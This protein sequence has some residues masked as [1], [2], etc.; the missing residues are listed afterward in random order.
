MNRPTHRIAA[1]LSGLLLSLCLAAPSAL[2]DDID[3]YR[4]FTP[5]PAKPPL[6]MVMLDLSL[7]L[8]GGLDPTDVIC[9]DAFT[10]A[11]CELLRENV[12]IESFLE[13]I[14]TSF[15]A[16]RATVLTLTFGLVDLNTY[17]GDIAQDVIDAVGVA[18]LAAAAVLNG[19][20]V[21][22]DTAQTVIY[23]LT[24]TIRALT[25]FRVGVMVSHSDIG[26]TTVSGGQTYA[27][28]FADLEAVPGERADTDACSNG[29]YVFV[30]FVDLLNDPL[31]TA[32]TQLIA[33]VGALITG[34]LAAEDAALVPGDPAHPYQG[35]ELYLEFYRYLVGGEVFNGH[36]G[37]F[38]YGDANAADNLDVSNPPLAWDATVETGSSYNS[39]ID[40]FGD[41]DIINVVNVMTSDSSRDAD[42]DA[43][44]L[45]A[46]PG[47]DLDGD[48]S[49]TFAELVVFAEDS[50][51]THDG[52]PF[53][54]RSRFIVNGA[55]QDAGALRAL[56]HSVQDSTELVEL[57]VDGASAAELLKTALPIDTSLLSAA[58]TLD[59]TQSG[60]VLGPALFTLFRPT[61]DTPR[62]PG[63]LKKLQLQ[64]D[65][66]DSEFQFVDAN[67]QQAISDA[68]R[69]RSNALT[70]WTD[71]GALSGVA[72][73]GPDTT[74]GGAG[75]RI[76]GFTT[77]DPGAD[78]A[79]GGRVIYYDRSTPLELA[80]L[81]ANKVSVQSALRT[82]L[83]AA[84]NAE[85]EELLYYVRG[86]DVGTTATPI[87]V[88]T[89]KRDWFMGAVFH[90]RPLAINY[91]QRS[92]YSGNDVRI[93]FGAADG[94]LRMIANTSAGGAESGAE[95]WAFMPRE[96]MAQQKTL[97]DEDNAAD[98]P[99]GVD[100]PVVAFVKDR[101]PGGSASDGVIDSA[102]P[103][104]QVLAFFGLRRGGSAYYGLDITD[105]DSPELLW[106]IDDS[107]TDFASLGRTFSEPVVARLSVDEGGTVSTR[108]VL[109]FGG[110]YD[111]KKDSENGSGGNV[112]TDDSVGN[113]IYIV[114]AE[115]GD[116][117]W[118]AEQGSFT[119]ADFYADASKTY[120][121][122]LLLDSIPSQLTVLDTDG[123]GLADRYYVGDTGGRL[124]RGDL[125]GSD[126]NSWTLTPLASIGRHNGTATVATDR[127]FFHRP[128][129]APTRSSEGNKFDTVL[130]GSGDRAD[131]ENLSA[132]DFLY[133][134]RDHDTAIGKTAAEV[135]TTEAGLPDHADFQDI[136]NQCLVAGGSCPDDTALATG[137]RLE[138]TQTGEKALSTPLTTGGVVLFSSFVP[139]GATVC[140]PAE[141]SARQY[142][143][144]LFN[145]AP[146]NIERY[147]SDGDGNPRTR[148]AAAT[149]FPAVTL[150]ISASTVINGA[151][152]DTL[153]TRTRWE[154][155]WRE[156]LGEE[157]EPVVQP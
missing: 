121:H 32:E 48:G 112:G 50:G 14:G 58:V 145:G 37:Y 123:D 105:P 101:G 88:G 114:D 73:D 15:A 3:V 45:Q 93:L 98:F 2:A 34:G 117:I 137:W 130:I 108:T 43:Q 4:N 141:G 38:D 64:F 22:V 147:T 97:R 135:I 63:N 139:P 67:G 25:D 109:F 42:S 77:G 60:G 79:D 94:L 91:G 132:E 131:P 142:A 24:R 124:W 11:Q 49:V 84:D 89:V 152:V 126:R 65:V 155:Y 55:D 1:T 90:S 103:D 156:R 41:C 47:A 116:L 8:D 115:T 125:P 122:D 86:W 70:F 136:T 76:P 68:G 20:N 120:A 36:L 153:P 148:N 151:E 9:L 72:T 96:V 128:D 71:A 74:A 107:L 28:D 102:N 87:P 129:Y 23:T 110:G 69:I 100:G 143:V 17:A 85:A 39:A 40:D 62:W 119:P 12:S 53:Q 18:T 13:F 16:V 104:D 154:T 51:F 27:C 35:K 78:N 80:D 106:R 83:G 99:Y 57:L 6:V 127:R 21:S 59:S 113:A 133:A 146:A 134:F 10:S 52:E 44:L 81:D 31:G 61:E 95:A 5:N 150:P 157:E 54:L 140:E 118:K 30:G 33:D 19:A 56:G 149:G 144:S 138:L 29:G 111:L 75:Q 82:A 66:A 26:T 7:D 92:G 46:F